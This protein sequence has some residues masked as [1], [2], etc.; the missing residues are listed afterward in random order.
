MQRV[1]REQ[2]LD[3]L[4]RDMLDVGYVP[5]ADDRAVRG[6]ELDPTTARDQGEEGVVVASAG[7]VAAVVRRGAAVGDV[8]PPALGDEPTCE[9]DRGDRLAAAALADDQRQRRRELAVVGVESLDRA[10]GVRGP[11]DQPLRAPAPARGQ[12]DAVGDV[13]LRVAARRA[14][15]INAEWER[16]GETLQG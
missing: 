9:Q 2:E 10:A 4:V 13:P 14:Q 15:R 3:L 5:R 12:R 6:P 11:Q 7:A 8:D 1:Q 16:R